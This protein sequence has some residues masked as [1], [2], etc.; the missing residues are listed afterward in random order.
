MKCNKCNAPMYRIAFDPYTFNTTYECPGCGERFV[1]DKFEIPK[2]IKGVKPKQKTT[3]YLVMCEDKYDSTTS[4]EKVFTNE[5]KAEECA[6]V[7]NKQ[8]SSFWHYVIKR[9]VEE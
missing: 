1:T 4:V 3:V 2:A 9:E 5:K 8:F 6:M 7:L